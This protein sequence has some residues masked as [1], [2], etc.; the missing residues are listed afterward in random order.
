MRDD[1]TSK[2][3]NQLFIELIEFPE[4]EDIKKMNETFCDFVLYF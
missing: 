2:Q 3:L 1:C 4:T